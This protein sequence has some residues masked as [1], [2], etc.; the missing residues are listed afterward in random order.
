MQQSKSKTL[1]LA[2]CVIED[3]KLQVNK[4]RYGEKIL[5]F[6]ELS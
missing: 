4:C 3:V 1:K 2:K 6:N 5:Q